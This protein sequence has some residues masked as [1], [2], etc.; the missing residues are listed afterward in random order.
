MKQLLSMRDLD[1]PSSSY[2]NELMKDKENIKELVKK[3]S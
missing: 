1:Q 3:M 2:L